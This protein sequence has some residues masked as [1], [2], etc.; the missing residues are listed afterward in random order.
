MKN[1][2]KKLVSTAVLGVV[3]LP[4]SFAQASTTLTSSFGD[5][6]ATLLENVASATSVDFGVDV[7]ME[8]YTSSMKQPVKIH[9]DLD[10]VS[11]ETQNSRFDFAASMTDQNGAFNTRNGSLILT[12]DT[13][14]FSQDGDTWYF[15]KQ[16]GSTEYPTAADTAEG[17]A[18]M[19]SA[20][21]DMFDRGIVTYHYETVDFINKKPTVRYAY[22]IDTDN[23]VD[24]LVEKKMVASSGKDAVRTYLAE[25]V[26]IGGSFWV[27]VADMLPTMFTLNVSV[28][29]SDASYTTIGVSVLFK[30]FNRPTNI[31]LPTNATDIKNYHLSDDDE[32]AIESLGNAVSAM[33]TDG[34]G[35]TNADEEHVWHS[36]PFSSD[37]DGDGY[38]DYTEV[39]N[40]YDPNGV[41][42]LDSDG[43]GLTDYSEMTV[44]WTNRFDSDSDN[45]GYNDGLEIANGYNPNGTGRW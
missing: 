42:K 21:Q 39:I 29:Q 32:A 4:A 43:D 14:Y 30:S 2:I 28:R 37:T 3:L 7:D 8:T 41:G 26:T 19:Q 6:S 45:D 23:L 5:S 24:Y 15:A 34:D 17:I 13:A 36:N 33:D 35:V 10:G 22:T 1:L 18:E 44:H 12:K 31:V 9:L 20:L 11:S 25:H 38:K 27:D 40:G 16:S